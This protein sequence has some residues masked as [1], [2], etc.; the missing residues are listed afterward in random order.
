MSEKAGDASSAADS[1]ITHH[2]VDRPVQVYTGLCILW[3]HLL[4]RF[5]FLVKPIRYS[6]M[7]I[8]RFMQGRTLYTVHTV[9]HA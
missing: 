9:H 1:S 4:L 3:A 2:I 8:L 7:R 6:S 5:I